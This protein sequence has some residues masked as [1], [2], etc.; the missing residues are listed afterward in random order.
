MKKNI[1]LLNKSDSTELYYPLLWASSKTY[2]EKNGLHPDKFN[3]PL[4]SGD[5]LESD[6]EIISWIRSNPPSFFGISLYMW[7]FGRAMRIAQIVRNEFP[8]CIIVTGGPQQYF[9]HNNKWFFDHNYLNA[10]LPG[11]EYGERTIA[12]ILDQLAIGSTVDWN[13]VNGV[14]YPSKNKKTILNSKKQNHKNTFKWEYSPYYSQLDQL[15]NWKKLVNDYKLHNPV[16]WKYIDLKIETTRGCPYGCTY[17]DWGGGINSKVIAKSVEYVEQDILAIGQ[18]KAR[19]VYLCDANFGI[20]GQ[21]DIDVV[22]LFAKYKKKTNYPAVLHMGGFAKT[23]KAL[24]TIKEIISIMAE[25]QLDFFKAYKVSVQSL[26]K[27]VMSNV[28]RVDIPFDSYVELANYMLT[29]YGYKPHSELILGLPGQ[30]INNFYSEMSQ[31]LEHNFV[32]Q[33]YSWILLPE[34]P[35]YSRDYREKFKLMSVT[36]TGATASTITTNF[37]QQLVQTNNSNAAYEIVKETYSYSEDNYIEMAIMSSLITGLYYAGITPIFNGTDTNKVLPKLW[38]QIRKFTNI[39]NSYRNWLNSSEHPVFLVKSLRDN[40]KY[41]PLDIFWVEY[42]FYHSDHVRE[43]L[44]SVINSDIVN[45]YFESVIDKNSYQILSNSHW[46]SKSVAP[47]KAANHLIN[48]ISI[49]GKPNNLLIGKKYFTV[50]KIYKQICA[51]I[52]LLNIKRQYS[53]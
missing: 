24:G 45:Q 4:P 44:S 49:L 48:K 22:N 53:D 51:T 41:V 5:Y 46:F 12:D 34:A 28:D 39:V 26:D 42:V 19:F 20:L 30:T 43:M 36:K 38:E 37:D 11:D 17:C 25:N 31:V 27:T 52:Y 6:E 50:V 18:L 14:V 13:S 40:N 9:K 35:A 32:P 2:Y 10:S 3:W 33:Y 16:H 15:L 8:D 21:R 1:I 29:N 47:N 7:N 23:K